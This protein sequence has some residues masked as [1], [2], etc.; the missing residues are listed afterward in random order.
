MDNLN[1]TDQYKPHACIKLYKLNLSGLCFEYSVPV[2]IMNLFS[3]IECQHYLYLSSV[4][5]T[6][7]CSRFSSAKSHYTTEC[8]CKSFCVLLHAKFNFCISIYFMQNIYNFGIFLFLPLAAK[9]FPAH[10]GEVCFKAYC[11]IFNIS[12]IMYL[13]LKLN[14]IYCARY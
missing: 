6:L 9:L 1:F 4:S 3:N 2:W 13:N 14:F 7:Q 12:G 5:L 11:T 8:T 10:D